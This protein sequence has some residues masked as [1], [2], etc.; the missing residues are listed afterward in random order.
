MRLPSQSKSKSELCGQS[1]H[2]LPD[3]LQPFVPRADPHRVQQL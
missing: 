1:R 3:W 2:A